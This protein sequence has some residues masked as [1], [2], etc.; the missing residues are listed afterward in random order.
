MIFIWLRYYW[1]KNNN[2]HINY[3]LP[4]ITPFPLLAVIIYYKTNKNKIDR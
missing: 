1:H 2:L 4:D 3:L